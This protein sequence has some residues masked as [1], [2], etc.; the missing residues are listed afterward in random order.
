MMKISE[1]LCEFSI[2]SNQKCKANPYRTRRNIKGLINKS[3]LGFLFLFLIVSSTIQFSAVYPAS[4]PEKSQIL[5]VEYNTN[6]ELQFDQEKSQPSSSKS[7]LVDRI[8]N[9]GINSWRP[10]G[11]SSYFG[12]R[13]YPDTETVFEI[14]RAHV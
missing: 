1:K 4:S 2:H 8:Y 13:A 6:S 3:A 12:P 5:N 14:G 10:L 7:I 11:N 9:N